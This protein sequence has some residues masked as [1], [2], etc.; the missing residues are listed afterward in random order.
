MLAVQSPSRSAVSRLAVARLI[1][2]TGSVAASVA[3]ALALYQRTGSAAWVGAALLAGFAVPGV[4]NLSTGALSDRLD[5]RQILIAS[6]LLGAACFAAMAYAGAPWLLLALA[7]IAAAVGAPFLPA[8]GAMVPALATP[9]DLPLAN[10]RLAVA[11]TLGRLLGP[12]VG[13]ALVAVAGASAAFGVNAVSFVIS[14]AFAATV[15]G[16]FRA[17]RHDTHGPGGSGDGIRLILAD[18]VLR[19][20]TLGFV[21]VDVGNGL[22]MPAEVPLAREFGAGALGYGALMA[23]WAL[24]G[25]VGSHRA[26]SLYSRREEPRVVTW[27]AAALVASFAAVPVAPWFAVLLAAFA[28]GGVAM[29]VVGV[30]EDLLLQR[31]TPDR[32]RGRVNAAHIA[33]V[34]FSLAAPLLFSGFLVDAWGPRAVFALAACSA[35]LG[36]FALRAL[37]RRDTLGSRS[38]KDLAE[39]QRSR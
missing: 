6:D 3:L 14:A 38:G 36:V 31:R 19:A 7:V 39:R 22:V 21:L 25:I 17:A 23:A 10:S 16:S 9:D 11:L 37:Q 20:L 24:G 4:V 32:V 5:R 26:A 2:A 8:S 29:G 35:L 27:S 1:S 18:P 13:G 12:F 28:G 15:R 30:G 33:A 34:Q